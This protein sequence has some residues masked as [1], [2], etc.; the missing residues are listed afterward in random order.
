VSLPD[1]ITYITKNGFNSFSWNVLVNNGVTLYEEGYYL[2]SGD[3]YFLMGRT[4]SATST[5][6][7]L[8]DDTYGL[9][10]AHGANQ[11]GMTG[12]KFNDSLHYIA[13]SSFSDFLQITSIS[14]PASVVDI[15]E[16]VFSECRD[17][18]DVDL[19]NCEA[20]IHQNAFF[21]LNSDVHLYLSSEIKFSYETSLQNPAFLSIFAVTGTVV[22]PNGQSDQQFQYFVNHLNLVAGNPE[23]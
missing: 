13:R 11:G 1:S 16:D 22:S 5:T 15:E 3:R 14:I 23:A 21:R 9:V 7:I 17:L 4:Y 18:V 10:D 2:K 8:H 6:L 12:V 20:L 19:S